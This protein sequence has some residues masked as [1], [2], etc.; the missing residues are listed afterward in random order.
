[1]DGLLKDLW[2][3]T[4]EELSTSSSLDC[5]SHPFVLAVKTKWIIFVHVIFSGFLYFDKREANS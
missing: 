4:I 5:N 1:M 2:S 3:K